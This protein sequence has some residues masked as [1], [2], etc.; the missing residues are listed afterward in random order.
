M[1]DSGR[2]SVST[3]QS[4]SFHVQMGIARTL[5]GLLFGDPGSRDP[6]TRTW[7]HGKAWLKFTLEDTPEALFDSASAIP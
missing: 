5:A 1:D 3:G 4:K 7:E 6:W 2:L